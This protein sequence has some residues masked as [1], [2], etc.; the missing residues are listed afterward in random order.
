MRATMRCSVTEVWLANTDD[1]VI[2][3]RAV[4]ERCIVASD[5]EVG[6]LLAL[7]GAMSL[8]RVA[9]VLGPL[10]P[11]GVSHRSPQLSTGKRTRKPG[12]LSCR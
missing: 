5:A 8:G 9:A 1:P 2:F 10:S 11:A 6:G 4:D 12:C 7:G 3:D